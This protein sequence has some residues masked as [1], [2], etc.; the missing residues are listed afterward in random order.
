MIVPTPSTLRSSQGNLSLYPDKAEALTDSLEFQQV[1]DLSVQPIIEMVNSE[2]SSYSTSP[3][4]EP[5][6]TNPEKIQ[7]AIKFIKVNIATDPNGVPNRALKHLPQR[8]FLLLLQIFIAILLNYH[9]RVISILK[10][11]VDPAYPLSYR[12]IGHLE[13]IGK[14]F[15]KSYQLDSYM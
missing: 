10:P 2:L 3:V 5:N 12:P 15:E 8:A 14:I 6:L 9:A 13:T 11:G 7:E 4:N 1:N